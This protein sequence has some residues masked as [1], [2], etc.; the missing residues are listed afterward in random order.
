M[1]SDI[2]KKYSEL[3]DV[4]GDTLI[5]YY[6]QSMYS[7]NYV[8]LIVANTKSISKLLSGLLG[9]GIAIVDSNNYTTEEIMI[10]GDVYE[11]VRENLIY[12]RGIKNRIKGIFYE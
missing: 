4:G 8:P 2:V 6:P 5:Y 11:E 10:R 12:F 1:K 3:R 9:G 7:E